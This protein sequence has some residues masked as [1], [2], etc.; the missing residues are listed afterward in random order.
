V[1]AILAML[2]R[3]GALRVAAGG[4]APLIP[5]VTRRDYNCA[6]SGRESR[7]QIEQESGFALRRPRQAGAAPGSRWGCGLWVSCGRPAN[8]QVATF[9]AAPIDNIPRRREHPGEAMLSPFGS[10]PG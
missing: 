6:R 2:S 7:L 8:A 5:F 4:S 3:K 9:Y 10:I 1:L